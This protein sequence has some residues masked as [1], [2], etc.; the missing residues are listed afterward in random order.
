[1]GVKLWILSPDSSEADR[2]LG[3]LRLYCR[4]GWALL[5]DRFNFIQRAGFEAIGGCDSSR[6]GLYTSASRP[7]A[8][9]AI[10]APDGA[11]RPLDILKGTRYR[12]P[13]ADKTLPDTARVKLT[14]R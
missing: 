4:V 7:L 1:M 10:V 13:V 6:I 2:K 5:K 8:S 9:A 3:D 11:S 12:I 14:Y